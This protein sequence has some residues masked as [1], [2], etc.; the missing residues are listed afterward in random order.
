MGEIPRGAV[1]VSTGQV[2][3]DGAYWMEAARYVI[4][5]EVF[6]ESQ[7]QFSTPQYPSLPYS[8]FEWLCRVFK[9]GNTC[10]NISDTRIL[11]PKDSSVII[12]NNLV[13]KASEVVGRQAF[14]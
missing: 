10:Y 1:P 13:S 4:Y 12:D 6:D 3:T 11:L 2:T 5:E 8:I 7:R 14:S 9:K